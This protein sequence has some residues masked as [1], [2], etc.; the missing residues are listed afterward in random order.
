M[1]LVR[2][3]SEGEVRLMKSWAR[4]NVYEGWLA[5]LPPGAY[6]GI[7]D[8]MNRRIDRMDVVRAQYV[9]SESTDKWFDEYEIVWRV[10]N[11]DH[12][13]SGQF[14]GLILWDVMNNREEDWA[15]HKVDKTIINELD[16]IEDIEVMEYFRVV[17]FPRT[18]RWRDAI[19]PER[20]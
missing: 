18:G 14:I 7:V 16:M 9:V 13:L 11:E 4:P 6:D 3:T 2:L 19:I 17:G 1:S 8:A 15:F 10:M 5:M 20:R 12:K